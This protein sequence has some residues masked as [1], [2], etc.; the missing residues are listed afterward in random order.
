[1]I[2]RRYDDREKMLRLIFSQK[3][4]VTIRGATAS[5]KRAK[6]RRVPAFGFRMIRIFRSVV[7][8]RK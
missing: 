7:S 6:D 2:K 4:D 1:M 3:K 8:N 5:G